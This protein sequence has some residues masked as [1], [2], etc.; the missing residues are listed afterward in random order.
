MKQY[1]KKF[2]G[3]ITSSVE[4]FTQI[5]SQVSVR[6]KDIFRRKSLKRV[7]PCT[8]SQETSRGLLGLQTKGRKETP[9]ARLGGSVE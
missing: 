9:P 8:V 6:K 3:K 2:T 7:L 5:I 1:L 4:L